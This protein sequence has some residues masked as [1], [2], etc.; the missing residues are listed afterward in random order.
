VKA[1]PLTK[2]VAVALI[3]WL[4]AGASERAALAWSRVTETAY[5]VEARARQ[6]RT[7]AETPAA[8]QF[9]VSRAEAVR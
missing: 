1:H 2:L 3:L 4:L 5:T 8:Q 6:A 7:P 9:M